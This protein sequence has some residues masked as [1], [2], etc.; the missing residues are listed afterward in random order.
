MIGGTEVKSRLKKIKTHELV[1]V[2]P[3]NPQKIWYQNKRFTYIYMRREKK[4]NKSGP[5]D[6]AA[7]VNVCITHHILVE[8]IEDH[9]SQTS[10]TPMTVHQNELSQELKSRDSKV[11]GH[12]RLYMEKR[13][14]Y[15][16][17]YKVL[18]IKR[19]WRD[20]Y[21]VYVH[22]HTHTV[23]SG[24]GNIIFFYIVVLSRWLKF[25]ILPH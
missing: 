16:M 15:Q 5:E 11:T 8:E 1:I 21:I 14:F 6:K 4:R 17:N 23:K 10:V 18:T 3:E 19:N 12:H 24:T 22:T 20:I 2:L 13:L 25:Y 9:V 7:W